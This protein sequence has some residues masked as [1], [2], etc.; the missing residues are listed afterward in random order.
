MTQKPK[1]NRRQFLRGLGAGST[2]LLASACAQPAQAP[3]PKEGAANAPAATEAP[4]PTSAPSAE[5]VTLTYWVAMNQN[6]SATLKSFDEMTCYKEL[7]KATNV[8]LEF[9]HPAVG[10]EAEQFNL[11]IASGKFPDIIETNWIS[12]PGGPGKYLRDGVILRH[13]DLIAQQAPN[14][15]KVLND[16]PDWRRQILTDEGDLYG[17]PF[18]RSD[19]F[20]MVFQGPIIRKDWLDKVGLPMPETLDDWREMLKAFRE[21]DPNGNGQ[22]DE[23]GFNPMLYGRPLNSFALSGAF[24]GAYGVTYGFYQV[25]GVVKY[26]PLEPAFK[27]FLKTMA[28]WYQEGLIDPDFPTTDSKLMDAKVTGGQLG[29]LVQ[30]TGGGIG[31]YMGLMKGKDPSFQLVAAPY[32]VLKKGDKPIFGQRDFNFNGLTAA[33]TTANTKLAESLKVL[34]YPYGPEGHMLFNFGVEGLTYNLVDGYPKY[35]DLITNH[36]DKLPLQQSMGQH[37]RSNFSGPFVQDKR[38]MEQ[39]AALPEQQESLKIWSQ[40]TNEYQMPMVTPTQDESRRFAS[41]MS[42]VT[43]RCDEAVI[44]I[45][46]GQQPVDEWDM[47]V[48]ELK[49]MGVEDAVQIQ[50]AALE[51]FNKRS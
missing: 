15:S 6:V 10:Q 39:Y 21:K 37:F 41:V 35:T 12:A 20:L 40:P 38:Y 43:T 4:A 13:N 51:R 26:G 29:A 3:A 49:A 33:I 50:Q 19:P 8:R 2:A 28:Q 48:S 17:F 45:I 18:I 23:Q 47:V 32:P 24:V 42:D 46:T 34:D 30:N 31:K 36:P 5:K 22:A 44:K 14:L 16:H 27:D 9:Q 1:L 25:Q 7:E 11:M